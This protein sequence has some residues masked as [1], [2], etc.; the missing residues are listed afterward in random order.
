[1]SEGPGRRAVSGVSFHCLRH[2]ANTLVKKAG[3]PEAVLRDI[4]GHDT[5]EISRLYTQIDGS[6]LSHNQPAT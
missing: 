2:T 1:M 5:V 4:V 6:A 3:V